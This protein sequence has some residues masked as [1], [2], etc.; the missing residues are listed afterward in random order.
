MGTGAGWLLHHLTLTTADPAARSRAREFVRA[1]I[2]TAGALGAPAIIGS[3]QG[4]WGGEVGRPDA[5]RLLGEALSALAEQ[6]AK[7]G[8]Q[9]FYEPLNRYE[10][11]LVNTLA[12]GVE[13]LRSLP[14]KNVRLLADLFH[15]NIEETDL[16]AAFIAAGKMVGHVHF[17]D[18]N[19]RPA[20]YG[21]L[22]FAPIGRALRESGYEGLASAEALSYPDPQTAAQ[23]TIEA[24]RKFIAD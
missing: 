7:Y 9:L 21:H 2:D 14:A 4:R 5:L 6:A 8:T 17:V 16:A 15:M 18:S 22:D 1:V 11:N 19:R 23:R 12:D 24:Y 20:G 3:M 13:L 10:T